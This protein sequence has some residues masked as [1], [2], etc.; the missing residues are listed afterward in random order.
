MNLDEIPAT[1]S[2]MTREYIAHLRKVKQDRWV[3]E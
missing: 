1:D 3:L 2:G